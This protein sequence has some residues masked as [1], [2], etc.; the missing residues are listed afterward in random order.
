MADTGFPSHSHRRQLRLDARRVGGGD[1]EVR[2][3]RGWHSGRA[4]WINGF[5]YC[6]RIRRRLH[7]LRSYW[8]GYERRVQCYRD[9]GL[10]HQYLRVSPSLSGL[11]DRGQ[12][13]GFGLYDRGHSDLLEGWIHKGHGL[14]EQH[15]QFDNHDFGESREAIEY[16]VLLSEQGEWARGSSA[17]RS[18]GLLHGVR[19][20]DMA[21]PAAAIR[22]HL[23]H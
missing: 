16:A 5:K 19:G 3:Y 1:V 20:A 2:L 21:Q 9:I 14:V 11:C 15:R 18:C 23:S 17:R 6:S 8:S 13:I 7:D 4:Q 12:A 22:Y 10:Y